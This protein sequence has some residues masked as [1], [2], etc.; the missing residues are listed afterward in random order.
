MTRM[1]GVKLH[2]TE[3]ALRLVAGKEIST[4]DG[5]YGIRSIHAKTSISSKLIASDNYF[6]GNLLSY[7]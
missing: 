2:F 6:F 5:A 7:F 3:G 1:N 4:N